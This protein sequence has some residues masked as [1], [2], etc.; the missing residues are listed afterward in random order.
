MRFWRIRTCFTCVYSGPWKQFPKKARHCYTAPGCTAAPLRM[1]ER[2]YVTVNMAT[3]LDGRI[4]T[5]RRE[6][7]TLG[8][9][10]DRHLMDVLRARS[11][12]VIVGAGTV[13]HDGFPVL[14]RDP[15]LRRRRSRKRP[16]HP[17]N[18]ILSR[19]LDM[20]VARGIFE[21]PDTEKLV[22]TTRLAPAARVKRFGRLAEVVVLP[23]RTLP[24]AVVLQK[25]HE[26]GFR[27]VLVEGGGELHF[28]FARDGCVDEIYVTVTPHLI[29]GPA[30]SLLDG[31]GFLWKD[32]PLLEL[33]SSRRAGDE[34]F[35][36]YRVKR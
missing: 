7:V 22:I 19:A 14:V 3:S 21:H 28:A 16:T 27:K 18:V 12:A 26:R 6:N 36:R 35:L 5:R 31:P 13:R 15:D 9:R 33:V 29:G 25:L 17:V 4:S 8:T 23:R 11:D 20:P 24:A 32:H 30:P 2:P 10:Y 34:V 1:T